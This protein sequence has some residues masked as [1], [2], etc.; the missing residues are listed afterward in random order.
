MRFIIVD[1]LKNSVW[2]IEQH[3]IN[4][5]PFKMYRL[6]LTVDGLWLPSINSDSFCVGI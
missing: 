2:G 1:K 5:V 4:P 6:D 3:D